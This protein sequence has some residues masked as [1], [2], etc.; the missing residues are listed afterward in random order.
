MACYRWHDRGDNTKTQLC[1]YV[2]KAMFR[3]GVNM[4]FS[5][6]DKHKWTAPST[7]MNRIRNGQLGT[8]NQV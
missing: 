1:F 2:N 5:A 3:G 8:D 7:R 6:S 4:F